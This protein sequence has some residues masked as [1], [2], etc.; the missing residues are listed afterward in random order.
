[1]ATI[2]VLDNPTIHNLLINLSKEE[3]TSFRDTI[4]QTLE[5]FSING[6][7]QY[8]PPPSILN[9]PPG[10]GPGPDGQ[11]HG[12]KDPLHDVIV[13]TDGKGNP[14]GLLSSEE[15]T[16]YR[17]SMNAMV[18]F[19][20]RKHVDHIVIFGAGMQALWHTRL[21]LML[22]GEEVR[23]IT[24]IS[25]SKERVDGLVARVSGENR[26]RWRSGCSFHY[27]NSAALDAQREIESCLSN[28]DCVFCT[29]PSKKPLFAASYLTKMEEG[30][31]RP[32]ISAIGSWQPDMIELDPSLL[33]DT[34][35]ANDGYNPATGEEGRGVILIDDRDFGLE[36]C[37]ELVQ[38]EIAA[39]GV[40]EIGEIIALRRGVDLTKV[41]EGHIE[42]VNQFVSEGFSRL[43]MLSWGYTR[44][45]R[46]PF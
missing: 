20:W 22:R 27:V 32:L 46:E 7:R 42:N 36:S 24:Y 30:E 26:G 39:G 6:E 23:S 12:R 17:T 1:M 45:S 13:L 41:K 43:V 16:G 8:Q 19:S 4:E 21:I 3:T 29:T 10:P 11:S 9:Q 25:P 40:V 14:T 18:S 28:A 33:H 35:A 44:R 34:I 31:R 5:A 15:V 2:Q 38:S 37:G